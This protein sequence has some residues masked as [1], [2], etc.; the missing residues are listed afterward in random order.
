MAG[1]ST[2]NAMPWLLA[3]GAGAWLLYKKVYTP[4]FAAPQKV[5]N[6]VTRMRVSLP[7]ISFKGQ[8]INF[9]LFIQNPNPAPLVIDAIVGDVYLSYNGKD[10]KVGTVTKFGQTI[11]KPLAETKFPFSVKTNM[12]QLVAYFTDVYAGKVSGQVVT[13]T[14]TITVNKRPFPVKES[15]QL[16][17]QTVGV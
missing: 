8:N 13:F 1:R 15:L 11:I 7:G 14:G 4:Q 3:A 10:L 17:P 2:G 16:T 6:Q 12:L 9:D 5:I